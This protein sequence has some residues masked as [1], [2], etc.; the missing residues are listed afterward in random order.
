MT[1]SG[2]PN[3]H[4]IIPFIAPQAVCAA[5]GERDVKSF[6]SLQS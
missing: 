6:I 5:E 2:T 4:K 1:V 3:S